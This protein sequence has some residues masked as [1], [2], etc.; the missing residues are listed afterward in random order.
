MHVLAAY[1]GHY[2][3]WWNVE[4]CVYRSCN[5]RARRGRTVSTPTNVQHALKARRHA[6][7]RVSSVHWVR[8]VPALVHLTSR[9]TDRSVRFS[10]AF[11]FF[12]LVHVYMFR[13]PNVWGRWKCRTRKCSTWKWRTKYQGMKMQDLK[14]K[15]QVSGHEN[16]GPEMEGRN[17]SASKCRT[18]K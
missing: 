1:V 17:V 11:T 7:L 13:P 2:P 6:G 12:R 18:W 15:D 14:M 4:G 10:F 9:D 16:V 3:V 8:H 5:R